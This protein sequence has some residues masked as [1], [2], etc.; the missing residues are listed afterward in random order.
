MHDI[1]AVALFPH[2]DELRWDGGAARENLCERHAL[3]RVLEVV[4][5]ELNPNGG[6]AMRHAGGCGGDDFGEG[7]GGDVGVGKHQRRARHPCRKGNA[8]A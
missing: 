1:H 3:R 6:Y 2:L 4:D 5:E 8:P 7:G